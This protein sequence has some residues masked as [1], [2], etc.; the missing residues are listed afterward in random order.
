[1]KIIN[2]IL[3]GLTLISLLSACAAK[4]RSSGVA[5]DAVMPAP[6]A[7]MSESR[8]AE[9]G[10]KAVS[11]PQAANSLERIVIKNANLSIITTDPVS[12]MQTVMQM[13]ETMGGF[14]VSSNTFKTNTASGKEVPFANLTIRVPVEKLDEAIEKIKALVTDPK[15]DI[16]SE[17]ISG[18]D[19]TSEVT[20]LDSRLRNLQE[21]EKQLIT[22]MSAATKTEDVMAVF[23]ELT[24]VREQIEVLQ[25]QIKYYR[26]SAALS[27]ISVNIQ[28]KASIEPI[29]IGSWQPGVEVQH[30]LQALLN[31]GKGL[32]NFLIWFVIAVLPVLAIIAVPAY[33]IYR[34]IRR[35]TSGLK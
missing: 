35:K 1:M 26:E 18:Q 14:V 27:A 24:S 29:T 9:Y 16:L 20:D 13:A 31:F 8:T 33:Y 28:A 12:S 25:G 7:A 11:N 2:K 22:I 21:A 19:V 34:A 30:A 15:I 10:G 3:I 4:S 6:A 23:R 5:N 32:I 17:D